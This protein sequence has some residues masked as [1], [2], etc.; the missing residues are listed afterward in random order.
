MPHNAVDD[1][2][3]KRRAVAGSCSCCGARP[4]AKGSGKWNPWGEGPPRDFDWY[5]YETRLVD[6]DGIYM[7]QLCGDVD[8][9]GCLSD[10]D[11]AAPNEHAGQRVIADLLGD[12]TD[13]AQAMIEDLFG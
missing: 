5:V 1:N 8:G 9:D 3:T 6:S 11:R 13:G 10:V 4:V 12:D 7:A 2:G